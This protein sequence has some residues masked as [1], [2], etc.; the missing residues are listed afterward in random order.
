MLPLGAPGARGYHGAVEVL[1]TPIQ[2]A[3]APFGIKPV[4]ADGML[5]RGDV[6]TQVY[7]AIRDWDLVIADLSDANPN[8][9]YE[10][11]LCHLTGR[12]VIAIAEYGTLPFD[13]AHIRTEMFLFGARPALSM[14]AI[15]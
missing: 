13:V 15:G 2:P 6:P 1:G 10:L 9:M 14:L 4:R 11:A 5:R 12:C 7:E 3:C 8:V